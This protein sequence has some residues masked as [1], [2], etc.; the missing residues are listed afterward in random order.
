MYKIQQAIG[1]FFY[2]FY[3][4]VIIAWLLFP[5][6][7]IIYASFQGT[8]EV[9]VIP[10]K[11]SFN[12][13]QQIPPVYWESLWFSLVLA[14]G[15]ATLALVITIPA[16]W[17]VVRGEAELSKVLNTII[18]IPL[19]LPKIILGIALLRFFLPLRLTNSYYGILLAL[20]GTTGIPMAYRYLCAIIEGIDERL[21]QA[22]LTLGAS[23]TVVMARITIPLMGPG[24]VVTWLFVFMTNFMNFLVI[25]FIAG[26][27]AN[28]ISVRL[29][30]E[31][32]E[33]GAMPHSIAMSA[34]LI[35]VALAFYFI[36]SIWLGPK[37]LSGVVFA[38]RDT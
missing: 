27:R 2:W 34:I 10:E 7:L 19:I 38:K 8:L 4:I 5:C 6:F 11:M 36:V 9:S 1:R 37:Y 25:Y 21:E 24:I 31:V 35:Y 20:V 26:P 22:A 28:P 3:L 14:V 17:V 23:R 33:R 13:Y 29:F 12:S 30:S 16:S 32:V 15:S 18:M